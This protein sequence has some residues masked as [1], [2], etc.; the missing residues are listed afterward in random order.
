MKTVL[1]MMTVFVMT[2]FAEGAYEETM[3]PNGLT[4]N[5]RTDFGLVDDGAESNQSERLQKAIDEVSAKG[6]GR[7]IVP[8]GVYRFAKVY[9]KSNVHLLIEKDTVIKP[10]WPEGT[11]TVVFILDFEDT[12]G[13]GPKKR[14]AEFIENV[15]IRGLG[16]R[17]IVDYSDRE[18]REGEGI[19]TVLCRMVRNFLI[20][21]LDIKDNF[22]VY[23]GLTMTP[24]RSQ[25]KNVKNWKISRATDGTIRNCRIFNA[26][27]GYGLVQLHGA[28]SLHFEDLYAKGGVTLRL[29]T[30]AVGD[31]TA[32]FDITAK[33]ITSENGRCAVMFG[34]H[35]ANN[36]LVHVDGVTARSSTYAITIG[37]GNVKKAEQ[38]R[39]PSAKPGRFA[40]GCSIR[41]IHAVFGKDA[42]VKTH[43]MMNIPEEYYD[44]LRLRKVTK[45]FDGPSIGAVKDYTNGTYRVDIEN[46]TLD[47][48]KYNADKKILTPEDARPGKWGQALRKWK[49]DRGIPVE[50]RGSRDSGE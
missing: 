38:A 3:D 47:G 16:G 29:E 21:D 23:C 43:E 37:R 35:S 39:N 17:F 27:P 33:N 48:F 45:F 44:D 49:A 42:Q 15:S 13:R 8:K 26:S 2:A 20:S 4:M 28:Q 50:S 22:T 11:K 25:D 46:V 32:V 6:G 12:S 24:T 14:G 5:L 9:L 30:G 40:D 31:H 41:N 1:L 34:P 19:R 10:Y 18:R 7:L 36:G